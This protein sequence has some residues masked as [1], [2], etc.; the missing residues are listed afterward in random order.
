[1]APTTIRAGDTARPDCA[2]CS[3]SVDEGHAGADVDVAVLHLLP[4]RAAP[5]KVH[6]ADQEP[7][8]AWMRRDDAAIM[9]PAA[10]ALHTACEAHDGS[11]PRR[12]S[13]RIG[14]P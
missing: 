2:A 9:A 11:W 10:R 4:A 13:M 8:A 6:L 1:M 7:V 12:G 5:V 3:R 14:A